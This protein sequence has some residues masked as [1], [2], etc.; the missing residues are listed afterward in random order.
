[1]KQTA[2]EWLIEQFNSKEFMYGD[3]TNIIKQAKEMEKQQIIDAI[4]FGDE[5]GKITT[6]KSS[7]Q[8]YN[9]TFKSE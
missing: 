7:E 4:N 6:Y 3:R 5:R 8:Y 9:E 1:M 2:A